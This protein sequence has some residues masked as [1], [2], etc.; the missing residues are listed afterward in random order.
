MKISI[1]CP[2]RKRTQDATRLLD[3]INETATDLHNVEVVFVI[4]DDDLESRNCFSNINEK[5]VFD[6]KHV[7]V[8]R[9]EHI[10]SDLANQALPICSGELFMGIGDDGVFRTKNWDQLTIEEFKACDD[11]ILVLH[12]NELASHSSTL[13]GHFAIHKNFV[14]TLGYFSPPWFDGDWGDWWITHI[15]NGVGRKKYR[16]DIIIEHLNINF[17]KAEEDETFREHKKR[18]EAFSQSF[19]GGGPHI[20]PQHP[21]NTMRDVMQK[22][23][24]D[25]RQFI[26]SYKE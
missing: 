12:Y 9:L 2:T 7:V 17:G 21:F 16:P 19:G 10:F 20:N 6:I 3:S 18:R 15:A 14:E 5:Y 25:L 1:I 22:N 4:D 23:I 8:P 11:K 13:V 26:R 24:E